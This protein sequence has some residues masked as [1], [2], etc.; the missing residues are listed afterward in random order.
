MLLGLLFSCGACG[1][2]V[3]DRYMGMYLD[4]NGLPK[5]HQSLDYCLATAIVLLTHQSAL[6]NKSFKHFFCIVCSFSP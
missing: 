2:D 3:L 6:L 1:G 4:V 5:L